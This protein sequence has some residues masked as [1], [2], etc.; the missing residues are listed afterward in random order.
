MVY[1]LP[2]TDE[3]K[4]ETGQYINLGVLYKI[5]DVVWMPVWVT[6]DPVIVGLTGNDSDMY[7]DIDP[8]LKNEILAKFKL[9]EEDLVSKLSFWD[10]YLGLV[11][12]IEAFILYIVYNMLT[13]SNEEEEGN[14]EQESA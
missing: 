12:L 14:G 5:S 7:Y 1:D 8:Q 4:T 3:H 9:K 11:V 13:G 6:S 10:K 2:N